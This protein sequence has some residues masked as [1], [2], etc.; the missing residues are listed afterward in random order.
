MKSIDKNIRKRGDYMKCRWCGEEWA[1]VNKRIRLTCP[2]CLKKIISLEES[3]N[4]MEKGLICL[5]D[6]FGPDVY[7]DK[8]NVLEFV[9]TYFPDKKRER[10]FINIAYSVGSVKMILSA[11]SMPDNR[12]KSILENAINQMV[13]EYGIDE[14]WA[15]FII[16]A[17]ARSVGVSLI[18][19]NSIISLRNR[20]EM[21]DVEAQNKIAL[22]YY[23]HD[24]FVNYELWIKEAIKNNS[25]EARFHFGVYLLSEK[26]APGDHD[27]G[28]RLLIDLVTEDDVD[29]VCFL[30]RN[31]S[32][33][34]NYDFDITPH[35]IA[36]MSR[37]ES[38]QGSN[39]LDLSYY[40]EN[41]NQ[42]DQA[43]RVIDQAYKEDKLIAW[44]RY[45]ELLEMRNESLDDFAAGKILREIAETGNLLGVYRLAEK[46]DKKAKSSSD[47]MTVLYW[48]KVAA[49]GGKREARYRLA[50]I[51]EQGYL[52]NRDIDK[53]V[54]WY[55]A[56]VVSGSREAFEKLR[57]KSKECIR[58][59]IVLATEDED[60]ECPVKGVVSVGRHDYL[61]ISDPDT[62]ELLPLIYSED[63]E[64]LDYDIEMVDE[65]DEERI[66]QHFRRMHS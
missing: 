22:H 41:Q 32:I 1:P 23:S 17:I 59:T 9:E 55:E 21:G 33:L 50:E 6:T 49:D 62:N 38:L 45:V 11:I 60:I 43:I 44:E 39:W 18:S 51:Y 30:G 16:G 57:Y 52:T 10:N 2:H 31:S 3:T 15:S 34:G 58:K 5:V 46:L 61:I 65:N 7:D 27:E 26:T 24:D 40:Y 54:Y 19:D 29:A 28:I 13:D 14:G 48:Y 8:Q 64:R 36:V 42:L 63:L 47:M 12:K 20:A 4:D 56:A 25:K 35:I 66:I 53:A 37:A